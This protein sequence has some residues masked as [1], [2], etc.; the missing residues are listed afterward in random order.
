[1]N[2]IDVLKSDHK[3]IR[4]LLTELEATT[5]RAVKKRLSLLRILTT[6]IHTHAALEE[7]IFYP[8]FRAAGQTSDDDKMFFEALEEHRAAG[9][10]V[11]PDLQQTDPASDQFSGRAKVLKELIEHHADEEEKEMFPRARKLLDATSLREL[12][13]A[14]EQRKRE[15]ALRQRPKAESTTVEFLG[16]VVDAISPP[17][18]SDGERL[19]PMRKPVRKPAE[20]VTAG[21]AAAPR[22]KTSR[23]RTRTKRIDA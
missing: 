23:P 21:T 5:T 19:P 20:T 11:L 1:M 15:L 4:A 7:E 12:G 10:L 6:E 14:M 16:A 18:A 22:T 9:E 8:A 17:P 13:A 3:K 2:A